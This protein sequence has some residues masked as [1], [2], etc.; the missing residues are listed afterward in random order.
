MRNED[1]GA[2]G[3]GVTAH[4]HTVRWLQSLVLL[5]LLMARPGL[6]HC[7]TTPTPPKSQGAPPP[8]LILFAWV[9]ASPH[10]SSFGPRLA[11]TLDQ[12]PCLGVW[13]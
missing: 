2:S 7:K 3:M 4:G 10:P 11:A 13:G 8:G 6:S 12:G 5:G 9:V 1:L